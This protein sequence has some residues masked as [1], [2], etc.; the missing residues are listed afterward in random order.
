MIGGLNNNSHCSYILAREESSSTVQRNVKK[1]KNNLT[2]EAESTIDQSESHR[3]ET[4][5]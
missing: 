3:F 2:V 5:G 4:D 1:L